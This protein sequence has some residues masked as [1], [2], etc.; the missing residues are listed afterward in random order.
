MIGFNLEKDGSGG[1]IFLTILFPVGV[2][3]RIGKR[4]RE[5]Y[6]WI[7]FNVQSKIIYIWFWTP[8]VSDK[9]LRGCTKL[10]TNVFKQF[11]RALEF[12]IDL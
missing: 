7:K 6:I 9:F 5:G 4:I 12:P 2:L 10:V 1:I 8:W 3:S 11:R